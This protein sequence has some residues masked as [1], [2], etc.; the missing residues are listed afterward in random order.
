MITDLSV[1]KEKSH[2]D[3]TQ[4]CQCW[5]LKDY[6]TCEMCQ[7]CSCL[8]DMEDPGGLLYLGFQLHASF[9]T[10]DITSS[11]V[12]PPDAPRSTEATLSMTGAVSEG[13]TVTFTCFSDANPPVRNHTWYRN[14]NGKVRHTVFH[15]IQ[16]LIIIC[17]ATYF[18]SVQI[19]L[20]WYFCVIFGPLS[21]MSK[22]THSVTCWQQIGKASLLFPHESRAFRLYR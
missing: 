13:H 17:V 19:I 15:F 7:Y 9:L 16:L 18:L 8:S 21:E 5:G 11:F 22:S 20:S 3:Q 2:G 6:L 4:L 1:F 10:L 14:D 12:V